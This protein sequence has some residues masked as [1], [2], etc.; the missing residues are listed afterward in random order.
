MMSGIW[1]MMSGIW[2]L[3]SGIW[4]ENLSLFRTSKSDVWNMASFHC[5]YFGYRILMSGT[6]TIKTVHILDITNVFCPYSRHHCPYSGHPCPYS[7]HHCSYYGHQFFCTVHVLDIKN[8][9]PTGGQ[10]SLSMFRTSKIDVRNMASFSWPYSGHR[11]I[12]SGIWPERNNWC[13]E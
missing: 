9:C 13:P 10:F 3:M 8:W 6:W 1:T 4:T 12:M 7:G 11:K 5:P 2:T